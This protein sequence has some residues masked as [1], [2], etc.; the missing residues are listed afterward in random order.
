LRIGRNIRDLEIPFKAEVSFS[1][2]NNFDIIQLWYH[3]GIIDMTYES[4][5]VSAIKNSGINT[6]IHGAFD[7]NDF[8]KYEDDFI[9]KLIELKMH[10][11]ILHPMIKSETVNNVTD[12]VLVEKVL[13]MCNKLNNLNITVYIEN[14]HSH[15]QS[16]YTPDQWKYFW[17]LAPKNT[18]FL[19]DIVH[20]LFCDDYDH[21][22]ELVN[23]KYPKAL[24]V[25]D[26]V[27]GMVGS[28]HT[29]LPIG[30]GIIDFEKIFNEIL[31]NY[32]GLIIMEI[33]NLDSSIIDSRNK[34]IQ[35][36]NKDK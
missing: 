31:P 13:G 16:F 33:K 32:D 36:L 14:N 18:E 10:E 9:N 5:P 25:A 2:E 24:H 19:L 28:K 34:L 22:K 29:H 20:V 35:Y 7:I 11:V 8:D 6:I 27:K 12:K 23:I 3:K 17:S 15:M 21:L 4:D 1:L 26:T 30:N